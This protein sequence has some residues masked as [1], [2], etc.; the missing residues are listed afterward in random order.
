MSEIVAEAKADLRAGARLPDGSW[1]GHETYLAVEEAL[2]PRA[3]DDPLWDRLLSDLRRRTAKPSDDVFLHVQV[4]HAQADRLRAGKQDGPLA[5]DLRERVDRTLKTARE[6]L[7]RHRQA[8]ASSPQ[9]W[10]Q[11][12]TVASELGETRE[13]QRALFDEGLRR[14]PDFEPIV[15]ARVR[16]LSPARGGSED[17][18]MDLLDGIALMPASALKEGLYARAVLAAEDEGVLVFLDPRFQRPIWLSSTEWL[19]HRW[20]DTRL[21]QRYFFLAC[22]RAE[23]WFANAQLDAMSLPVTD[24]VLVRNEATLDKCRRFATTG[25]PF[26]L[27]MPYRGEN[28]TVFIRTFSR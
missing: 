28:Q 7:D 9:W 26:P 2:R 11:R 5:Q 10:V 22:R 14:F 21:R 4:L 20:P 13:A 3:V 18:M 16:A 8:L 6:L 24:P 1:R 19:L 25:Q 27:Q 17:G 23:F 15:R 12:I